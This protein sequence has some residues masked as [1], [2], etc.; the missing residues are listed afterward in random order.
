MRCRGSG[1]ETRL[2]RCGWV[3]A[4]ALLLLGFTIPLAGQIQN[5][6]FSG[7]IMDPT[8][9]VIADAPVKITHLGT[10]LSV[11]L[12]SDAQGF[13]VARE[14]PVGQYRI[15]AS[16]PGFQTLSKTG[17]TLNAGTILRVDFTLAVGTQTQT[18]EVIGGAAPVE[19]QSA[20][21][22]ETVGATQISN[23]PLNG[24]NVYDLIQLTAGATNVRGVMF[25]NGA[26]TVVNGVRENF[27]GFLMNGVSN[28]GLSGGA[29]NQPIP[30]T[31][32]EFQLLTLNNS[33]EFGNSA[34]A[35]TNLVTKSGTNGFHGSAWWFVRNDVFDANNF[36]LNQVG[37]DKPALRFNQFG[38]TLGG[39]IRKDKFF[40][41]G[42]YQG[43][44]FVTAAPPFPVFVETPEFRQAVIAAFPD[45]V[46]ALLYS[47]FPPEPTGIRGT[48][49]LNQYV[50]Q[51]FSGSGFTS[52]AEYLCPDFTGPVFAGRFATL[53][54]VTAQDQADMAAFCTPGLIP[55]LQA[56]VFDRDSPFLLD[57]VAVIKTQSEF[58][59]AGNLFHGNEASL[60]L[61]YNFSQN[62]RVFAQMN[63]SRRSDRFSPLFPFAQLRGF[64]LPYKL[65]ASNFQLSYVH[66]FSPRLL[67]EFRAGYAGVTDTQKAVLP[68]VPDIALDDFTVGFGS[69]SG[70][71]VFLKE[72]IY[73]YAD[74]VSISK[75]NHSLKMGVDL[76]R[77]L[78]NSEWDVS[79]SVYGFFDAL[80]FAADAP[81]VQAAGVD[82][83]IISG[84]PAQ[85]A[86]NRRHFRNWELGFYFHDDWRVSRSLTLNLGLRYDL[87]TRHSELDDLA[88]TFVLGPG[89]Q[90]ID[91][92]TTGEGQVKNANIPA[93]APGC[94]LT[95]QIRLAQLAGVCGPGGFAP[96]GSLG[97][98]DHNNFGPR[99]GFAWDVFGNGKTSLRG[100]F[101]VSYEGTLCNPLS[102][103][104]WNL[105][106]FSLNE[107]ANFLAGDIQNVA[108][109]P[110]TPG[111]LPRFTGSPDPANFQGSD[112]AAVGNLMAW[113][114]TNP[115]LAGLTAIVLPEGLR[116]PYVMNWFLGGQREI[117][118]NLVLEVNYVGTAGR[119]LFRAENLNRVPGGRLPP[120]TCVE[121]NL[122]RTLCSQTD[123]TPGSTGDPLNPFGRL[124]PNF[125]NLRA[126]KNVVNSNYNA[127]QVSVRKLMGHGIQFNAN[128]TWSHSIDGGST[129]HS[130]QTSANGRSA[131]DGV[132]TDQSLP[133]L[134]RGNSVFDIRHRFVLNYI[135][136]L[137]FFRKTGG[138]RGT[139]LGGW[140]FSG[141]WSFQSGAH[142]SPFNERNRRFDGDCTQ[143][144]IDAGL[145]INVGGDYNLDGLTNDRP[146]A[147]QDH[148]NASPDMWANGFGLPAG[149]FTAPCLGCVGNL[150]RNTFVGPGYWAGDVSL[151]K[152]FRLSEKLDLQFR[153]EAF[154]VFNHTNFQLPIFANQITSPNFGQ[155]IGTFN[156]RNLQF[157][158][159]LSW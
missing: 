93:G 63:W 85:L 56:G 102:N 81:Y 131:G 7:L 140:Q 139:A 130:G 36:F 105:P 17:L 143:A 2:F 90:V 16:A 72:N 125:D 148:V 100:G 96:A 55:A 145:C 54:G 15:T 37:E 57:T 155:A 3:Y 94:D 18:I 95:S 22:S 122:G 6:Q 73:T 159:K 61:D 52:F 47:N 30:D 23:L 68:G 51:G 39:P 142:W 111:E 129:W 149:F 133:G 35:I 109:G 43:E 87:Y 152:K 138:V 19:T 88:T 104:R 27:N 121:D 135:W 151:L 113:D 89:D 32:Q 99:V 124:N 75:G 29:V 12:R 42:A 146:D 91:N 34:G 157:G 62:D 108:Y 31:V 70:W 141:I 137:P 46:A 77:N 53:F 119:K 38:A 127:L 107:A 67:N 118:P 86:A 120:G 59:T 60:R 26:N 158:L 24:R 1:V 128:Y 9:A 74:M 20:R 28:K 98:G 80:F 123:F 150:G 156:P 106:Y 50:P 147:V 79:R 11:A 78:E 8:G 82:P 25:E 44:R 116:D 154:N 84:Q 21:L 103:T 136:E 76:R 117:R 14:L 65:T 114:P 40:F 115:N 83:G 49:S 5:G 97:A 69:Y 134:D 45:S 58:L 110:Q 13:F 41:F 66:V 71:P 92:I 101:G 33:A 144:G 64:A 4:L 112:A 132:T 153:A 48:L 10:N 126:W